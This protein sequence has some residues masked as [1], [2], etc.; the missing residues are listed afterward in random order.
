MSISSGTAGGGGGGSFK[1]SYSQRP[2][3]SGCESVPSE[4]IASKAACATLRL[5][6]FNGTCCNFLH[7][8]QNVVFSE[9][10]V[11]DR[12]LGMKEIHH[13]VI[14]LQ[15]FLE[16]LVLHCVHQVVEINFFVDVHE[17]NH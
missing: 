15:Y 6:C 7:N 12:I 1:I 5:L 14:V 4:F 3:L 9:S 10:A 17:L 11:D 2:R 13:T 8:L 16:Q